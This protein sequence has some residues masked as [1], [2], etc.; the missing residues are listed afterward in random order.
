MTS[1]NVH[2]P[3]GE[4][5][6]IGAILRTLRKSRGLT[7]ADLSLAIERSQGWISQVERGLSD[8]SLTD[9][10]RFAEVFDVP[11]GLFFHNEDAP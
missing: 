7:L 3:S 9:L 10:R 6:S 1:I 5:G 2:A 11:I 4:S 8:I